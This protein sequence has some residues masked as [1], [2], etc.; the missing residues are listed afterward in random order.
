VSIVQAVLGAL[1]AVLLFQSLRRLSVSLAG[2]ATGLYAIHPLM[3]FYTAQILTESLFTFL[4]LWLIYSAFRALDGGLGRAGMMGA[5]MG[6]AILCRSEAIP[7]SALVA[8]GLLMFHR[9]PWVRRMQMVVVAGIAAALVVVPWLAR[10]AIVLGS[11]VLTTEGGPTFYI[12]NNPEAT[13]GYQALPVPLSAVPSGEVERSDYYFRQGWAF[14]H[15]NPGAFLGLAIKKQISF[16]EPHHNAVL[17]LSDFMLFPL[18]IMGLALAARDR[19]H[20]RYYY[21]IASPVVTSLVVASIVLGQ[22]RFRTALY[23][24]LI[25]FAAA[26]L[27][28]LFNRFNSRRG[29]RSRETLL[30]DPILGVDL[31]L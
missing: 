20:W 17:D 9:G 30:N 4:V 13:G 15:S 22:A 16:W 5:V 27:V 25:T 21:F 11:P 2:L 19:G 29:A 12:G 8:L 24:L 14:I 26:A 28:F 1:G 31:H 7:L 3:L 18:T 10:N 6:L 23:P